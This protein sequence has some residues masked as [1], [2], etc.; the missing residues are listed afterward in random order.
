MNDDGIEEGNE[1]I[2]VT[3]TLP[4]S[5]EQRK[6]DSKARRNVILI[7]IASF[8]LMVLGASLVL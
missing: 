4:K 8:V 2:P 1:G 5:P 6:K 3:P 7:V